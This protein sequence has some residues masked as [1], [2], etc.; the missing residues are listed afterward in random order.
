MIEKTVELQRKMLGVLIQNARQRIGLTIPEAAALLGIDADTLTRYELGA[1][2]PGLPTLKAL[3]EICHVPLSYFWAE[4]A[5]PDPTPRI[6]PA[7]AIALRR[8]MVGVLLAQA[9]QQANLSTEDAA[10]SANLSPQ[11]LADIELG[12]A[13]IPFSQLKILLAHYNISLEDIIA[14]IDSSSAKNG[15]EEQRNTPFTEVDVPDIQQYPEDVQAF[16]K[17][18]ANILYIKLAMKLHT[19]SANNLRALAEGILEITY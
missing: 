2:E 1:D 16:L 3:A 18:P 15:A 4:D 6:N 12:K 7:K 9:R 10:Q 14:E 13:D 11:V 8:K 17:D 5:L 19:L